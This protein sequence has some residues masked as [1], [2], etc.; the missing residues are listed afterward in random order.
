MPN[1]TGIFQEPNA[2]YPTGDLSNSVV[3]VSMIGGK[4]AL[5]DYFAP[6]NTLCL[7]HDDLDVGSSGVLIVPDGVGGRNLAV[8]ASKEGRIYLLDRNNLGKFQKGSDSQIVQSI[9]LNPLPCDGKDANGNK[10]DADYPM[11]IY[12]APSYWN[13][14]VYLASIAGPL[15]QYSITSGQLSEVAVGTYT[16]GKFTAPAGISDADLR[17]LKQNTRAPIPVISANGTQNG[18]VWIANWDLAS[19][20]GM[21]HAYDATN[22]KNLL[23]SATF[24]TGSHFTVP[25]VID[26]KVYV[27]GNK[28]VYVYGLLH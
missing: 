18:I 12:G 1:G 6:F 7:T 13:G 20:N 19:N 4:F 27:T 24:G 14:N 8:A 21:L 15:R 9:L 25:T 26:G 23:Y 11:R 22:V 17:K 2:T 3:K 16:Y 5:A 28:T 10:F